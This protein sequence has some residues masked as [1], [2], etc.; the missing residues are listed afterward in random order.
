[1]AFSGIDDSLGYQQFA[2]DTS[3]G[4]TL[5]AAVVKG[6]PAYF[7]IKPEAQAVRW[8]DDGTA[9]TATIGQPLA[10][11]ETL[12]YDAKNASQLRFIAQTAGGIINAT[13]YGKL[14]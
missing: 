11:G 6:T 5:T 7:L 8:R 4:L 2:C 14:P 13:A 9:P 3:T 10:V 1:M 12:R